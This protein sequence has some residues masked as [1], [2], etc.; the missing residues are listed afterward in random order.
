ME[1]EAGEDAA[2]RQTCPFFC[3]RRYFLTGRKR[4]TRHSWMR[5][6]WRERPNARREETPGGRLPGGGSTGPGGN[7]WFNRTPS[8]LGGRVV[9]GR[10]LT[11]FACGAVDTGLGRAALARGRGE[12]RRI[13]EGRAMEVIQ[14]DVEKP[15]S[16]CAVHPPECPRVLRRDRQQAPRCVQTSGSLRHFPNEVP[17][18]PWSGTLLLTHCIHLLCPARTRGLA[19][20]IRFMNGRARGTV[21]ALA[22]ARG[23]TL[24]VGGRG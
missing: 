3:L 13:K 11:A 1:A 7:G 4:G 8:L 19:H 6:P 12:T 15:A 16:P 14:G 17:P 10:T 20:G 24:L 9:Q 21:G 23:G 2:G 5:T 18:R 22:R